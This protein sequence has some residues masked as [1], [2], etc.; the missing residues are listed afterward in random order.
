MQHDLTFGETVREA[1][2][3]AK[4]SL[5]KLAGWLE[6]TPT[7]LSKIER[8]EMRPP[9]EDVINRIAHYLKYNSDDLMCLAGKIPS[10]ILDLLYGNIELWQILRNN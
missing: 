7:Y 10:D 5:R 9:A 4:I 2:I 1:R 3:N 8:N 6:I